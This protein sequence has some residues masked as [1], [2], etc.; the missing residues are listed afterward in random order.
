[1]LGDL[2]FLAPLQDTNA[3]TRTFLHRSDILASRLSIR[4]EDLPPFLGVSR[5]TLFACRSADSAVTPKS[6]LKLE[7]AERASGLGVAAE[8][9]VKEVESS[10]G[11]L[12]EIREQLASLQAEISTL[13]DFS[14]SD[15]QSRLAA[16]GALPV[17]PQDARLTPAQLW[18]K[19]PPA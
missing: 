15:L 1:M 13:G 17:S 9:P 4:V 14:Y 16:A 6:W 7:Q 2:H 10:S 12:G 3:Q 8:V 19:Y 11:R 5:R 18:G